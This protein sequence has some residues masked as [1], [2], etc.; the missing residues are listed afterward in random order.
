LRSPVFVGGFRGVRGARCGVLPGGVRER[1]EK[2]SY[3][4]SS[5]VVG[6]VY[7]VVVV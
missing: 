2:T 6:V 3:Q 7:G 1:W 4:R 5:E